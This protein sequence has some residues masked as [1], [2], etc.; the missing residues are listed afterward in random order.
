MTVTTVPS[1]TTVTRDDPTPTTTTTVDEDGTVRTVTTSGGGSTTTTDGGS[2]SRTRTST[3]YDPY[4]GPN[5]ARLKQLD[6]Q[7]DALDTRRFDAMIDKA[8]KDQRDALNKQYRALLAERNKLG[9]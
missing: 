4:A 2:T 6:A 1:Q 9:Y 7:I 8:P 3:A 5:G